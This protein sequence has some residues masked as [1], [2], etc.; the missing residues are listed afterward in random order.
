MGSKLKMNN[1][2]GVVL[3]L[4][5]LVIYLVYQFLIPAVRENRLTQKILERDVQAAQAKYDSFGTTKNDLPSLK[6][7]IDKINIA[8]PSGRDYPTILVSIDALVAKDGL[9]YTGVQ[10][11]GKAAS[12]SSG[13]VGNSMSFTIAVSGD[14]PHIKALVHDIENNLRLMKVDSISFAGSGGSL[15][16]SIAISTYTQDQTKE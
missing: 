1:I 6:E 5:I 2:I 13:A 9:S 3:V 11:S 10:P 14:F 7:A 12:S 15:T 8:V 16:S 4:I